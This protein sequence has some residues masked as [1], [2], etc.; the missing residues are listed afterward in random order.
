MEG[1]KYSAGIVQLPFWFLE[2]KKVMLLLNEGWILQEIK[3]KNKE[4]NIFSAVSAE[5]ANRSFNTVS[6]RIQSLDPNYIELFPMLDISNQKIVALIALMND[7]LLFFEFMY[8]VVREKL[9]LG[10]DELEEIEF[11]IFFNRKQIQDEKVNNWTDLTLKKLAIAY[12]NALRNSGMVNKED[13]DKLFINK[14]ILDLRLEELIRNTKQT[15]V[16]N[17]LQGVR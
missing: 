12:K 8:E 1:K 6:R 14:P 2:F 10:L 5:R 9:I 7:D 16:L 17:I 13:Q 4:E 11:S 15:A 3:I